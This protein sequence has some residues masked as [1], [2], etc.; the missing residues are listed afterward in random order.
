MPHKFSAEVIGCGD[1]Y[2]GQHTNA[3]LLLKQ[4]C[5]SLLIDCGP[6]VPK[7]LF[8]KQI[9]PEQ[10]DAVYVTHSHP[11]HCLGL[12]SLINWMDAQGR[13]KPIYIIAQQSQWAVLKPLIEFAYWPHSQLGFQVIWQ[14]SATTST[15][16]PWS[17]K[18]AATRHAVSNLS[19]QLSNTDQHRLFYSGDG[20]LSEQGEQLAAQ[21]DWVFLECETLEH[22]SSHGSWQD[23]KDLPR[24]ANSLWRLYHIDPSVRARLAKLVQTTANIRLAEEGTV[25]CSIEHPTNQGTSHVA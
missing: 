16:G 10:I 12:T 8:A 15:I 23:I 13:K 18:T 5:F 21:S 11:D 2:D 20:L 7:A 19:L 9:T 22:H 25:L 4:D 6:S 1:A 17:I 24:K 3:S 14:D